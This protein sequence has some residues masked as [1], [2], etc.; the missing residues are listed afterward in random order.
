MPLKIGPG[1]SNDSGAPVLD[2]RFATMIPLAVTDYEFIKK[3]LI[4]KDSELGCVISNH[5]D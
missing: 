2:M 1:R 5:H 3:K 4:S